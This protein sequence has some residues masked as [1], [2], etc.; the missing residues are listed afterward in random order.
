MQYSADDSNVV[1]IN[2]HPNFNS[3]GKA[4]VM[5]ATG[6]T[7]GGAYQTL[8]QSQCSVTFIPTLFDISANLSS[9]VITVH[10]AD[11]APD[12]DPTARHN[13]TFTAWRCHTLLDSLASLDSPTTGCGNYTARGQ[14]GLG[15]IATRA[16]RQL[17][18]LSVLDT[19]LDTSSL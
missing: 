5:I 14:P 15:N 18:D 8:N 1:S 7:P 11:S 6:N 3:T 19:S 17:N 4:T 16:L 12:M 13:A 2:A 10:R 9:S